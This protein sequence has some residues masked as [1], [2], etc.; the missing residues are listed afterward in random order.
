MSNTSMVPGKNFKVIA[1]VLYAIGMTIYISL[2]DLSN[3]LN[4]YE[5]QVLK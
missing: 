5:L 4:G 2:N 1:S 3:I